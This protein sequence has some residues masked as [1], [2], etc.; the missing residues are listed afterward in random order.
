[1][2]SFGPFVLNP[3]ERVL[4]RGG[5]LVPVPPKAF[6]LLVELVSAQGRV[7]S[8]EDLLRTV[9]P[10]SFVE[11][12]NLAQNVSILR[13]TLASDF[14][15]Q[16][17]IETIPR[18]GYRFQAEVVT[19]TRGTA[20]LP[21]TPSIEPEGSGSPETPIRAAPVSTG[22]ASVRRFWPIPI[23]LISAVA[24]LLLWKNRADTRVGFA[25]S[26][27]ARF[28]SKSTEDAVTAAAISP[29]GRL[30]V[31]SDADGV[32]LQAADSPA[33]HRLQAPAMRRVD[34]LAWFPDGLR[35][36]ESG[37]GESSGISEIWVVSL[38]GTA[39]MLLRREARLG[40]PSPDGS[41]V[42]F[43][44]PDEAAIWVSG[45]SG[46]GARLL[47]KARN[48]D[49]FVAMLWTKDSN[50]LL[51]DRRTP[52][53]RSLAAPGSQEAVHGFHAVYIAV[54]VPGG[55]QT[56]VAKGVRFEDACLLDSRHLLYTR[57]EPTADH[58]GSS[59][60]W[61]AAID[62]QSG[63]FLSTPQQVKDVRGFHVRSLSIASDTGEIVA[64]L[65][66]GWPSVYV[67]SIHSSPYRLDHVSRLSLDLAAAYPHGWTRDSAAVLYESNRGGRAQ[68]YRQALDRHD[69][70]ALTPSTEGQSLPRP[71]PD[72]RWILFVSHAEGSSLD[73]LF[74]VPAQGVAPQRVPIGGSFGE[75]R[76]PMLAG[77]CLLRTSTDL[78]RSVFSALDPVTGKGAALLTT[79]AALG[80]VADWDISPDGSTLVVL[81]QST[82][83]P[84]LRTVV[85][86]SGQMKEVHTGIASRVTAVN[87]AADSKGWFVASAESVGTALYY[88]DIHGR[89]TLL[90]HTSGGT[91]GV[92]SPNGEK[93]AFTDENIDSNVW[94]LHPM[95][96]SGRRE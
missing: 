28:T 36:V 70:D 37:I 66:Q 56:A 52:V 43:M 75:F 93:L 12:G 96:T 87:W 68:I 63:A 10:D 38:E 80:K 30:V 9:W 65:K 83:S 17:P 53:A 49:S 57:S 40:I 94:T 51:L 64:I 11:E 31:Y 18:V 45:P 29:S 44:T 24:C 32:L 2:Y 76:C 85:L 71:S 60:L 69:P 92:P 41:K 35:I 48:G 13:K 42:A 67:G 78:Q 88:V 19:D 72:G 27:P 81:S 95:S 61:E 84:L 8:K 26:N 46:E 55:H 91:W 23:L 90:R 54:G 89:S 77:V 16:S 58:D 34:H 6:S 21:S 20:A 7:I 14:P 73:L 3:E 33:A 74:R 86:S 4:R 22:Y 1:M 39:P 5:S 62:P 79:S 15:S 50:K 47:L 82:P 59:T 25:Y